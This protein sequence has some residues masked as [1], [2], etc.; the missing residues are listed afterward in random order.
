MAGSGWVA[1]IVV[2][3]TDELGSL[4]GAGVAIAIVGERR[5]RWKTV[6]GVKTTDRRRRAIREEFLF[7]RILQLPGDLKNDFYADAVRGHKVLLLQS[8]VDIV[9][10]QLSLLRSTCEPS[11]IRFVWRM[12]I[13]R[14]QNARP[15]MELLKKD[16]PSPFCWTNEANSALQALKGAPTMAPIL[17]M[18]NL[19]KSFV[20]EYDALG[21]GVGAVLMQEERPIAYF[22]KTFSPVT[23]AKSAYERELM[24]PEFR[25]EDKAVIEEEE[26]V[27][28]RDVEPEPEGIARLKDLKPGTS[29]S[30]QPSSLLS[31]IR[32]RL[33][34]LLF[35]LEVRSSYDIPYHFR[36]IMESSGAAMEVTV[37]TSDLKPESIPLPSKPSFAPLKAQDMYDGR[38]QFR[39]ISVPPH[40]YSP[41]KKSWMEIYTPV[42]EQMKID[43][44]MNLKSRKVELKTRADTP[45]ISNLQKCA[46]FVQ[47]FMM[48]FDVI[49]A[50]ALLRLDELY[51]ESF[52]IKDVKTLKGEHL[53]RAI[54]R[55][56]GKGGKTKFAIENAT[57]TRIVI[58][59]TK[60]HILGSFANI[61]VARNS[62]CSLILGSPAGKVYSK[63]RAVTSRLA[64]RF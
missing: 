35:G 63:L 64:E 17:V 43:I 49:D 24:F 29:I 19:L 9:G 10:E 6:P 25:L 62:L 44:R 59:D 8:A 1:A 12:R 41:L 31:G 28:E 54:G 5:R 36:G 21:T 38:V 45:D 18:P 51:L 42:Y 57:K 48:G 13:F 11:T 33:L 61:K 22:R 39:K 23:M 60:I 20:V 2:A 7:S 4:P 52:E 30:N 27:T 26:V 50:I 32:R 53:S 15:L 16:A 34:L 40:R 3:E 58:A 46:D 37:T 47:A 14:R 56:S 55:L